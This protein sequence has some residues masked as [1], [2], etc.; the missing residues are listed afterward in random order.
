MSCQPLDEQGA[1]PAALSSTLPHNDA[2]R[3]RLALILT[4]VGA[5]DVAA[6]PASAHSEPFGLTIEHMFDKMQTCLRLTS[7]HWSVS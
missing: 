3:Q 5:D 7:S 1:L 4:V 6:L 2:R